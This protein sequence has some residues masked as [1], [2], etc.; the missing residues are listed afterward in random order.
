MPAI[1]ICLLVVFGSLIAA[2][3]LNAERNWDLAH[4]WEVFFRPGTETNW[5]TLPFKKT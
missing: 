5:R 3:T 2:F 1:V 4:R